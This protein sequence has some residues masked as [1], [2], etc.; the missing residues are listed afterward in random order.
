MQQTRFMCWHDENKIRLMDIN[1]KPY[2]E[3][4][5]ETNKLYNDMDTQSLEVAAG[6]RHFFDINSYESSIPSSGENRNP[7]ISNFLTSKLKLEQSDVKRRLMRKQGEHKKVM[8]I[9]SQEDTLE[10]L[11]DQ[12]RKKR[13]LMDE[14]SQN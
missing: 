9:D 6:T 3:Q 10:Y 13:D 11:I 12:D 14:E 8:Y 5:I 4:I 7:G 1:S 2:T